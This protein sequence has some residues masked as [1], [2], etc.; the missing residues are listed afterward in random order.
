MRVARSI[1]A[2]DVRLEQVA[3]PE[4]GPGEVV[5]DVL[6]PGE[7]PAADTVLYAVGFDRTSGATMRDIYVTGLSRILDRLPL[8]RVQRHRV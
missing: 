6:A 5:C 4:P 2:G 7:L 3:D 1:G 8:V